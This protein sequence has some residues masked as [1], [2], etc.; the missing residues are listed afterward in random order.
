MAS[1]RIQAD[2]LTDTPWHTATHKARAVNAF[3]RF[4]DSDFQRAK[5]TKAV[6]EM[7]HQHFDHIAHFDADGFYYEWFSSRA[8][9]IEFLTDLQRQVN[10]YYEVRRVDLWDDVKVQLSA[11]AL[12]DNGDDLSA[13]A[14]W[15]QESAARV[16][17]LQAQ[18]KR[19]V[20]GALADLLVEPSAQV[21]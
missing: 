20:S 21:S 8:C 18:A 11:A 15:L 3:I 7:L 12:P 19:R 6:Y 17:G 13:G 16:S 1:F 9:Q 5:F 14:L 4:V 2:T 10:S